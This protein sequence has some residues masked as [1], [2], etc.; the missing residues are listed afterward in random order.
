MSRLLFSS[1]YFSRKCCDR[2]RNVVLALAQRREKDVDDV[3][4]VV[5][6]LAE[7]PVLD[8][9]PQVAVRGGD[10]AHVDLDRVH[11]A[12][13]HELALLHHAQQLGLGLGRDVADLV[14]EDAA[15]VGEIA[16]ALLRIDRAGEGALHVPEERGLEQVGREVAGVDRHERA[17]GTRAS[18]SGWRAR[19]APCRFRSRR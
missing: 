17:L 5:E 15:L 6:V 2:Q 14:E 11:A 1:P 9:L 10:D 3:Q 8:H 13:P 18:S 4:A 16:E 12:E 19:R 7:P